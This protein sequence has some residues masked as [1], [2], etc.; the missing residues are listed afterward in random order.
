MQDRWFKEAQAFVFSYHFSNGLRMTLSVVVPSILF[1]LS[2]QLAVGIAVSMGALCTALADVPGTILHKRNGLLISTA[3]IF[4]TALITG[5]LAPYK[6]ILT[7]WIGCCTFFCGMLLIYGNRGGNIG[8]GAL[9]IMVSVLAESQASGEAV[10]TA[11]LTLSGSIWYALLALL[12]WQIRPYLTVQQTLG[13]CIQVTADY[14]RMRADFYRPDKHIPDTYKHVLAQQVIVS[15]KQEAVRE[16]LLKMRSAQQGT[17]SISKSMVLIFLDLVDLFEEITASQIN[18]SELQKQLGHTPIINQLHQ[19]I[20]KF[21]DEL[22]HIGLAVSAGQRSLPKVNLKMELERVRRTFKEYQATLPT[23]RERTALLHMESILD[24]LQHMT[25]RMYNMHRLTRLERVKEASFEHQ[26]ELSKFTTRHRYDIT[27]FRNNLSFDSHIFRHSVRSA[28]AMISGFLLG[29]ALHLSK[30]YWILLTIVVIMKPGFSLTKMRSYQRIV[31]TLIGALFAAVILYF[32]KDKTVI[33]IVM[34]VC[35][36]GT[37]SFMTYNYIVSV[38]FITPFIIFLLHFLYPADFQNV[39]QRVTDTLIGGGIAFTFNYVFWP[40]WEYR[41]L[42]EYM[43]KAVTTSKQYLQQVMY[44]YTEKPFNLAAYKLARK[45]VHVSIANLTA[46]FQRMLS[47][48]K[49][50]QRHASELYHYVV[51]THSLSSHIAQLAAFATQHKLQHRLTEYRDILLYLMTT[52]DQIEQYVRAGVLIQDL[53]KP[54]AFRELEEKL[55]EL[56]AIRQEQIDNGQGNT[57]EREAMLEIMQVR[58]QLQA[59]YTVLKD[60]KK[61]AVHGAIIA[62]NQ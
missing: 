24:N 26:L 52:M 39:T 48:P 11:F 59:L 42:P 22:E 12:L 47:E 58:D 23:L 2:G 60:M 8:I 34:L 16:L 4:I 46:A 37:Y 43:I 51:L 50:K 53:P 1:A 62:E 35:I 10:R 30:T 13:D 38:V 56:M 19:T 20:L 9:L 36:L 57:P 21:G 3:L 25:Q 40:S 33:F 41:F 61:A 6:P 27:N 44:L 14:L 28:L 17:T 18:Y 49:S 31:G 45:E 55:E 32:I 15:E 5:L 7:L 29:Q 54:D